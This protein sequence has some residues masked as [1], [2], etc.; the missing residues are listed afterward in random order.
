MAH[1][2]R[3]FGRPS[4][5]C[6]I[7][8]SR[9]ASGLQAN[10]LAILPRDRDEVRIFIFK[11]LENRLRWSPHSVQSSV[12][13]RI[14]VG[15][16]VDPGFID[17]QVLQSSFDRQGWQ[18]VRRHRSQS[19]IHVSYLLH[20]CSFVVRETSAAIAVNDPVTVIEGN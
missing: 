17:A 18:Y 9:R 12:Q 5:K 19:Q 11:R 2:V 6:L 4:P 7:L 14:V 15:W 3:E 16:N 20:H 8:W 13:I 1:G 10:G